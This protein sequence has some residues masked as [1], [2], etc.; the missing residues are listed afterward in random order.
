MSF[1]DFIM[2]IVA[3]WFVIRLIQAAV[4]V[5]ENKQ[6]AKQEIE[7]SQGSR[8]WYA[9]IIERNGGELV[10]FGTRKHPS[11]TNTGHDEFYML[12]KCPASNVSSIRMSVIESTMLGVSLIVIFENTVEIS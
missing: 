12:V 7:P 10:G 11:E 4:S 8:D 6:K 1:F 2:I 9:K 3:I 5:G